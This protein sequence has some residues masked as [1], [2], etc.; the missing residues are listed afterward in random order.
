MKGVL[1]IVLLL[2]VVASVAYLVVGEVRSTAGPLDPSTTAAEQPPPVSGE[3]SRAI[4]EPANGKQT[5]V[6][7]AYYFHV[8]SRCVTCLKIEQYAQEA[9]E[10]AY[11]AEVKD[12]RVRWQ[13]VN[14]DEPANAHFVNKYDL[15]SSSLVLVSNPDDSSAAWRNLE[16]TW[17]LVGDE[18]AFKKYVTGEI[19]TMLR[20]EP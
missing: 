15:V 9:I 1:T 7:Q 11:S 16:R 3:S 14:Y 12:G 8:T 19:E 18:E 20:S 10:E 2:F 6:L 5:P 4:T 13:A 17:D